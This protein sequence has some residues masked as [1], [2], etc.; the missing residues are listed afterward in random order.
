MKKKIFAAILAAAMTISLVG[1]GGVTEKKPSTILPLTEADL[2]FVFI[3]T[4]NTAIA[5]GMTIE[6]IEQNFGVTL[7]GI[8]N[9][10]GDA[11]D[12]FYSPVLSEGKKA[13]FIRAG[14]T[15]AS[16]KLMTSRGIVVGDT[17]DDVI[18]VYGEPSETDYTYSVRR[19]YTERLIYEREGLPARLTFEVSSEGIVTAIYILTY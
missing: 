11:V 14:I 1:C 10:T 5:L 3:E 13:T 4:G 9:W 17:M 8:K 15:G 19:E 2:A 6:E 7:E 18:A 16:D 12:I